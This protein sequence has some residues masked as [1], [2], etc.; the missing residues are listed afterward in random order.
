MAYE[1]EPRILTQDFYSTE[2][3]FEVVLDTACER[4]WEKR[5]Q[6]SLR[7]IKEMDDE[8]RRIEEELDEFIGHK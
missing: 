6:Y 5:I 7:R 8:L 3:S 2:A 4:L 1:N